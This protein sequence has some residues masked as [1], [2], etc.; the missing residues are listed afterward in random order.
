MD[1]KDRIRQKLAEWMAD[2]YDEP[3]EIAL[4]SVQGDVFGIAYSQYDDGEVCVDEQ[5]YVDLDRKS[6]Y[7][8]LDGKEYLEESYATLEGMEESLEWLS[9][10]EL[11]GEADAEVESYKEDF[12]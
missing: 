8:E 1:T 2:E 12:R 7:L 11:I 6:M 4:D 10:D 9:F 5:W 3:F